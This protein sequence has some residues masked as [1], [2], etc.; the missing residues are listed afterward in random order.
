MRHGRWLIGLGMAT[1][2]YPAHR[3]PAS[4]NARMLRDGTVIVRSG[5]QDLGT[6]TY[7]VMTQIAAETLGLPVAR[8]RFELGDT[9]LPKAPVSGGSMT[10][11]SVGP[12]VETACRALRD[13]VIA[14]AAGDPVSPV[15]GLEVAD[16]ASGRASSCPA[17]MPQSESFSGR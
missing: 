12:A 5:T 16:R 2:T 15:Y 10:A 3:M 9:T 6:G 1:A 17:K 14:R 13:K 8:V 4:A 7:T 11:A